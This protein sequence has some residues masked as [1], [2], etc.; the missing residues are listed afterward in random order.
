VVITVNEK[1]Q[2]KLEDEPF[3]GCT[4]RVRKARQ[5]FFSTTPSVCIERAKIMTEVFMKTEGENLAVRLAK[6]FR[7]LCERGTIFIQDGE[8]IVGT[9]ASKIR[10][11]S[12]SPDGNLSV[13][14]GKELDI[15]SSRVQDPFA[16]TEDQRRFLK[17]FVEPYWKG[18]SYLDKWN[19]R[20]PDDIRQFNNAL[21]FHPI[22][23][24]NGPP[25]VMMADYQLVLRIGINGIRKAISKKLASLD[26]SIPGHY[27]QI[28]YLNA[29]L[30][31][32]DGIETRAK[33][34]ANLARDKAAK[35]KDPERKTELEKIAEICQQVPANPA[36]T[37]WE[38]L[39][40]VWTYHVCLWMEHNSTTYA[41]GRMD[42]YLY[43]YYKK[44]IQEGRLTKGQA[45]ELLECFW[46]KCGEMHFLL[47]E[48]F[49]RQVPGYL[50]IQNACCGGITE[51]G[52]DGV[53]DVSYMMLQATMDVR[54]NQPQLVIKYNKKN[55]DS[56]L[57]KAA[58]LI[59]LGM[60]HAPLHNDELG[61]AYLLDR[62]IPV[63]EAYNWAP[64]GCMEP[65]LAGKLGNVSGSMVEI[66]T[67]SAVE[68]TLLNGVNRFTK[69]RFPVPKTGDPRNFKTYGEF[70]D[71][72]K[73]QLAYLIRKAAETGQMMEVLLRERPVLLVSLT[74]E[75]CI[76][77][78][79]D[80]DCGG[81]K[82][83]SGGETLIGA[84]ADT[85]N[86]LAAIKKLIYEDKKLTWDELLQAL[87]DDFEGHKGIYEMCLSA[88]KYG[89]DIPE[90]DEIVAEISR[91]TAKE[92]RKYKGLYGG[93]RLPMSYA[94]AS[95]LGPGKLTG[96]L[97]SGRRAWTPV[98][99]GISPAQ[100][101]GREGATAVLKSV[102]KFATDI[103]TGSTLLNMKLDPSLFKDQRGIRDFM[104]LIKSWHNLGIF[105]VQFNVVSPETL[106]DA[107]KHPEAYRDMMV[108][109]SGYSA[110]Y[111][112]LNRE[113]Q[114]DIIK[115]TTIKTLA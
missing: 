107:Q 12:V 56:F 104:G 89:D 30:I 15:I 115:R 8:L 114:E 53:N 88:P 92:V 41:L 28:V 42:Q 46:V 25:G 82:Y 44:D 60:G 31:V 91:F 57:L 95:H 113:I 13:L 81:A 94:G 110:Y 27:E 3:G 26:A 36:R 2:K 75:D 99:D 19:A 39:Q 101:T 112:E 70:K 96:A 5:R 24:V 86:S 33:R 47:D 18:K 61:I 93:R 17:E 77:N 51:N 84:I 90:V 63:D 74:Y 59:A 72:V 43:P 78:G 9:Q 21:V 22:A 67:A 68:F 83:N 108:R 35:E 55:P 34:Y 29:L 66:N 10:G 4:L 38:A 87:D 65:R 100:G 23:R 73:T 50:S 20:V 40:S 49:V 103:F 1:A 71:A 7:E 64:G 106:R 69:S 105:Q 32:C 37:F 14:S 76:E 52:E 80:V 79:R 11:G 48:A 58:E 85:C 102:S 6:A 62:G 109:V 54:M 45:Q 97:P 98:S 16:I 111:V